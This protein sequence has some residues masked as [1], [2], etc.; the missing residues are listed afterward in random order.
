VRRADRRGWC[1]VSP[2]DWLISVAAT[3]AISLRVNG[4]IPPSG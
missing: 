1:R 4:I 3:L 2:A